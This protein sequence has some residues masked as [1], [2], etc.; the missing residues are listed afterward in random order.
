MPKIVKPDGTSYSIHSQAS[1]QHLVCGAGGSR[2]ILGCAGAILGFH[3]TGLKEWKTLGGISGGSITSLMLAVGMTPAEIVQTAVDLD[4]ASLLT[5]RTNPLFILIA[6]LLQ[7]RYAYTRPRSAV[8]GSE[9]LGAFLEAKV[10]QWPEGYWTM[11][12]AGRTQLLFTADGVFQCLNDGTKRVISNVPAPIGLAVRASCAV[13]GII[14][15]IPYKETL[16]FDGALSWDG[17]CP[18]G[19]V[20]KHYEADY[21]QIFACDVSERE[22]ED[23]PNFAAAFWKLFCGQNCVFVEEDKDI[24]YWQA[25]GV[26]VAH[27]SITSFKS[28]QFTLTTEQKWLAVMAG[29]SSAIEQLWLTGK[30]TTAQLKENLSYLMNVEKFRQMALS[31]H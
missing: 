14:E 16:L 15:A 28:L 8:M 5:K 29:F 7:E 25:Q 2:A 19:V 23:S 24:Y 1:D 10:N 22:E 3:R 13:P 11:A 17:Q 26:T 6:F 31:T 27:P 18:I 30:I 12:V 4:F 20:H 9:K 21:K